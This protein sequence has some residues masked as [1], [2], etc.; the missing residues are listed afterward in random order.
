MPSV[1]KDMLTSA[2][3]FLLGLGILRKINKILSQASLNHYNRDLYDWRMEIVV[4]TGGSGGLDDVLVR[5][6]AKR[7][8]KVIGLDITPPKRPLRVLYLP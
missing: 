2:L 8:V 7:N 4:V 5:K 1:S 3:S 6:L